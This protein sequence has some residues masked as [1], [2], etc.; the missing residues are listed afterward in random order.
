MK[1]IISAFFIFLIFFIS[2]NL[3]KSSPVYAN[4]VLT[5]IE[6]NPYDSV[7]DSEK[8]V[9]YMT[10]LGS[11]TIYS[12]DYKS[13]NIISLDLPY[14]AEKMELYDGG[15]YVTQHKTAHDRYD[16]GPYEAAIAKVDTESFTLTD[17]FDINADPYDIAIDKEG[18]L[19][20][21]PGSGQYEIMKVFSLKEK[22]EVSNGNHPFLTMWQNSTIQY[23]PETSTIY[24][25]NREISNQVT[26]FKVNNGIIENYFRSHYHEKYSL[27]G[28]VTKISPD[29]HYI[30]N[31]TY[32]HVF[33][34]PDTLITDN[35]L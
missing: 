23:N 20:V 16:F 25:M 29:G 8:Q 28:N 26:V 21:T 5:Q 32:G 30:Y 12:V 4:G 24:T 9:V 35:Q 18:Y 7:V 34:L 19:Y 15:L 14:P 6:F 10:K 11:N 13:G 17:L 31:S 2:F 1:K 22:K 33:Y 27:H 3:I